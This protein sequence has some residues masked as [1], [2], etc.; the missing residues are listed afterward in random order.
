M[1]IVAIKS[2]FLDI[3]VTDRLDGD[4]YTAFKDQAAH[5]FARSKIVDVLGD[6]DICGQGT[7][8]R[9][10]IKGIATLR[11]VQAVIESSHCV[12]DISSR[13]WLAADRNDLL[14]VHAVANEFGATAES[15]R[16]IT[17]KEADE[18]RRRNEKQSWQTG[19]HLLP[20][21][22]AD[23]GRLPF[24]SSPNAKAVPGPRD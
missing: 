14:L 20:A 19:S 15:V 9:V 23:P 17:Q 1:A 8:A 16:G 18:Y 4:E 11:A 2:L 12:T 22:I 10:P 6:D 5:Q 3:A 7:E 24:Y 13:R 21:V